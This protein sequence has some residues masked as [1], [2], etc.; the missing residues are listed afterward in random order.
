MLAWEK[1]RP[2]K[3]KF[4][5]GALLAVVAV[6]GVVQMAGIG[7]K[8]VD[9]PSNLFSAIALPNWTGLADV[10]DPTL[11]LAAVTFAFIAGAET[12][13]SA[14]AVDRMHSGARTHYDRELAAQ[15]IGNMLCGFFGCR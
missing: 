14:A 13:L 9:V 6:T 4:V 5:P 7:V 2:T 12:P 8:K 3:L 10:F 15:G 11:L 1:L